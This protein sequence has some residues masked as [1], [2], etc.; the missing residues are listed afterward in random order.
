MIYQNE[1]LM[2]YLRRQPWSL[3]DI[4]YILARDANHLSFLFE[5][6]RPLI[7]HFGLDGWLGRLGAP[8]VAQVSPQQFQQILFVFAA[9]IMLF[10]V[11][12]GL[13]AQRNV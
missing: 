1:E 11:F 3:N 12:F 5:R 8:P 10:V 7:I 4:S 9:V 6:L 2:E 13:V